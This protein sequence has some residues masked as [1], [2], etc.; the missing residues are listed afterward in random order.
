MHSSGIGSGSFSAGQRNDRLL[1]VELLTT[2]VALF[3]FEKQIVVPQ[4][5]PLFC[6]FYRD[7]I[8]KS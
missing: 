8:L 6:G 4:V 5:S 1:L 7:L 2:E 3:G